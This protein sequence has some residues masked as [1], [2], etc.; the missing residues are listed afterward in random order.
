MHLRRNVS[1]M[2]LQGLKWVC[3]YT[4]LRAARGIPF[5]LINVSLILNCSISMSANHPLSR[6]AVSFL[7]R[8]STLTRTSNSPA[9]SALCCPRQKHTLKQ[10]TTSVAISCTQFAHEL[11]SKP[12]VCSSRFILRKHI[13]DDPLARH[14]F[15]LAPSFQTSLGAFLL[16]HAGTCLSP[17]FSA[18]NPT[19]KSHHLSCAS[20][21][22]LAL[23]SQTVSTIFHLS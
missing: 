21:R 17:T 22:L 6:T 19:F 10:W 18:R 16:S 12:R 23:R 2:F 1:T 14:A 8:S 20:R 13:H 15:S 4:R 5:W 9:I 11:L 3:G 7:K